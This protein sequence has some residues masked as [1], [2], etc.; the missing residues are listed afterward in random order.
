M[1]TFIPGPRLGATQLKG[2]FGGLAL[3]VIATSG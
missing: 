3:P 2:R 1:N